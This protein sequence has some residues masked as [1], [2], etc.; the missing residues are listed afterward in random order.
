MKGFR[1]FVLGTSVVALLGSLPTMGHAAG[2]RGYGPGSFA[3]ELQGASAGFLRSAEG[4]HAEAEVISTPASGYLAKHLGAVKFSDLVLEVG[5]N[6][7]P[8]IYD[9]IAASWAGK[10]SRMNGA[11]LL[12]SYNFQVVARREFRNALLTATELP[13]LDAAGK[14]A[15]SFTLRVATEGVKESK[16]AGSVPS[17][18][19][20]KQRPWNV[21][22]F[23]LEIAGLDCSRVRKI[24]SFKVQTGVS[25]AGHGELTPGP[26]TVSD[27]HVTLAEVTADSWDA[28]A[29]SFIVEGKNDDAQEKTGDI[30]LLGADLQSEIARIHLFGLGLSSLSRQAVDDGNQIRNVVATLYCE[31]A[32]LEWKS[33]A[34]PVV[35]VRLF[36]R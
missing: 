25:S 27:F 2:I 11:V 17:T 13:T 36:N 6:M 32:T 3:L 35:N 19:A 10:S 29:Q 24:D 33:G 5:A 34:T 21:N 12:A 7:E 22:N 14:E 30:V 28:W 4:G 16:G 8:S 1:R 26:V 9:W 31:R 15:A 20:A 23:R 18:L